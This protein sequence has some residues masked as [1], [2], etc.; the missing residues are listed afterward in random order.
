MSPTVRSETCVISTFCA[1]LASA[2]IRKLP[3][4]TMPT[5]HSAPALPPTK[6]LSNI[7]FIM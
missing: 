6:T 5:H 7:G 3:K 1:M 4:I 2:R